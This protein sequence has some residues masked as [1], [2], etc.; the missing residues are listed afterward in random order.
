MQ[1][2]GDVE[3]SCY[4]SFSSMRQWAGWQLSTFGLRIICSDRDSKYK[5]NIP[6]ALSAAEAL[7][8]LQAFRFMCTPVTNQRPECANR[9][10]VN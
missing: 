9:E 4:C 6:T 10:Y 3:I 7:S 5:R 1:R 2:D 8:V